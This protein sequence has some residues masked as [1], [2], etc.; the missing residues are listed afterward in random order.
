M[1]SQQDETTRKAKRGQGEGTWRQRNGRWEYRFRVADPTTGFSRQRSVSGDTKEQ[2]RLAAD[3]VVKDARKAGTS[4]RI[5][6]TMTLG[7]WAARWLK[8]VLP[9]SDRRASTRSNYDSMIRNHI[10]GTPIARMKLRDVTGLAIE[11]HIAKRQLGPASKRNLHAC[12][13]AVLADAVRDRRLADNPI[14]EA[15]RP[16]KPASNR[17]TAAKALSD[18]DVK[19][20]TGAVA[21]HR[22][23]P[24]VTVA[25][26]TGMRRGELCG[27][28]WADVDLEAGTI[29]VRQQATA[30]GDDDDLK[31]INADRV[32]PL[33]DIAR[34]A[35]IGHGLDEQARLA[36]CTSPRTDLVFTGK[37]GQ[38]L[39][40]RA[41]SRWYSGVID[42]INHPKDDN[43]DPIEPT[44]TVTEKG[45]HSLRH[46]FASRALAA[47]IAITDVCAWLGHADPSI[48]LSIYSWALP[49]REQSSIDRL[50]QHYAS[51]T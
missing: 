49:G 7:D 5:V 32:I 48:T 1:S 45:L 9:T 18:V 46:T 16:R 41:V 36:R 17:S 29:H 34:D 3:K 33:T 26:H 2:C 50:A 42:G 38:A 25:L 4:A 15:K 11:T 51:L 19:A 8:D 22:L 6:D 10:I 24:L 23:A 35:L 12:L 44:V 39:D 21:G 20:I 40:L 37:T 13:A 14:R 30:Y 27:L 31:T 43:G 28:R 47:G